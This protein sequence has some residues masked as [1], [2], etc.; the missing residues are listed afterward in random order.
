MGKARAHAACESAGMAVIR[1]DGGLCGEKVC[2]LQGPAGCAAH[3]A[4]AAAGLI[5]ASAKPGISAVL[6]GGLRCITV[7]STNCACASHPRGLRL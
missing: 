5:S 3:V 6:T 2:W 7:G 1:R 4:G